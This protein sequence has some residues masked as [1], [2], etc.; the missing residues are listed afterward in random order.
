MAVFLLQCYF[1]E[2]TQIK[3]SDFILLSLYRLVV[4]TRKGRN[5]CILFNMIE[6]IEQSTTYVQKSETGA[7]FCNRN[8]FS[9]VTQ[10]HFKDKKNLFRFSFAEV[11]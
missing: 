5:Q 10:K 6:T 8:R 2:R 3:R 9:V 1:H 11:E 4:H 7:I